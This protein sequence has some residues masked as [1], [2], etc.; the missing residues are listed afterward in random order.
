MTE[1]SSSAQLASAPL[2]PFIDVELNGL[3]NQLEAEKNLPVVKADEKRPTV[4]TLSS[5]KE[6]KSYW[7]WMPSWPTSLSFWPSSEASL[8]VQ[9]RTSLPLDH[10]EY[11]IYKRLCLQ[12]TDLECEVI[13]LE[14]HM[15]AYENASLWHVENRS[16][17]QELG[18]LR[19][20]LTKVTSRLE[21]A[22]LNLDKL[23]KELK[24]EEKVLKAYFS[25]EGKLYEY[26]AVKK[27]AAQAVEKGDLSSSELLAFLKK[28]QSKQKAIKAE[29]DSLKKEFDVL[30][31]PVKV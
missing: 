12:I 13:R 5:A 17:F 2:E 26:Q 19:P 29:L 20:D 18:V 14:A 16:L 7:N 4:D 27:G 10:S 30:K 31:P 21:G 1:V 22:R 15:Q 24:S 28:S 6:E 8:T 11:E 25:Y 9:D 23:C 3:E